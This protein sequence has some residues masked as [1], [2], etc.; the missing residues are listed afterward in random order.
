M[1][2]ETPSLQGKDIMSVVREENLARLD[3]T[4]EKRALLDRSSP[5]RLLPGD[6]IRVT[7][8]RSMS[9][10][11]STFAFSG[12]IL[13]IS[14]RGPESTIVIRNIVQQLGVEMRYPVYSPMVK[15][16][17]V[18]ARGKKYRRAKLYYL[19]DQPGKTFSRISRK[20]MSKN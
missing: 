3:P 10:P 9:H 7:S 1:T 15:G 12:V 18:L 4:G 5:T 8:Y 19:R 13:G 6:T 17:E 16:I 11:A 14:R 20:A 2:L